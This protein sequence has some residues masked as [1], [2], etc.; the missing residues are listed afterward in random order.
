VSPAT[1]QLPLMAASL[2]GF[3]YTT[4]YAMYAPVGTTN[5]VVEQVN[6]ALRRV[7]KDPALE[8][9]I[10]PHGIELQGGSPE[11]VVAWTK[12]D[13]EKWSRIIREAK[14]SID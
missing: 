5:T 9:R 13:T 14:I 2:P 10:E 6:A 7:L 8:A 4:W 12:R 3:D 11:E 1:R